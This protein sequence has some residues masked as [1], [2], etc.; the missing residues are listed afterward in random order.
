VH[1]NAEPTA[2]AHSEN[3]LQNHAPRKLSLTENVVLTIKV[4][5]GIAI[6]LAGLW[7]INNWTAT[8]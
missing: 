5:G 1:P 4:L 2:G 8:N 6:L 3:A 7:G